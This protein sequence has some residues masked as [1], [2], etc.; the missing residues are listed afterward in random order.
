ML[1]IVL[2][3]FDRGPLFFYQERPGLNERP[4]KVIKFRTMSNE[5]DDKGYLL[6]NNLRI[7]RI[8]KFLRDYSLDELPQ[9]LNVLK[10][11]MS[12]VGPRP[13]LFKYIPL[14]SDDQRRRHHVRPGIT[15]L[16]QV[17]GRNAISWTRKFKY[18][19]FYV[20]NLTFAL[21]LKIL[22]ETLITV[23]RRSGIN[24]GETVTMPP[25]DG[26]N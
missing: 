9:L 4:F 21:D 5:R 14:F 8:G 22:V 20:D 17:R 15:G 23:I 10:G 16:A 12:L 13:L 26:K 24:A 19:I 2:L 18:D 25:F 6:P 11:D 3:F 7:T 1:F